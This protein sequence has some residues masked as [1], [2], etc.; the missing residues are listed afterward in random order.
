MSTLE[1]LKLTTSIENYMVFKKFIVEV[2]LKISSCIN[3]L[4]NTKFENKIVGSYL[5]QD[6]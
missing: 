6:N 1:W 5:F 4:R 3:E 2:I